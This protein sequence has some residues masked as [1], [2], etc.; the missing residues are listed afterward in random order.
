MSRIDLKSSNRTVLTC[1]GIL[2]CS[3]IFDFLSN[4][5]QSDSLSRNLEQRVDSFDLRYILTTCK[6]SMSLRHFFTTA[7]RFNSVYIFSRSK[8]KETFLSS[9]RSVWCILF[10]LEKQL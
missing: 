1:A 6:L 2:F 8:I 4:V 5:K 9:K 7:Q 3:L 10:V